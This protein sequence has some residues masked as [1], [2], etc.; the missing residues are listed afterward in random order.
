[1]NQAEDQNPQHQSA[2]PGFK[3]PSAIGELKWSSDSNDMNSNISSSFDEILATLSLRAALQEDNLSA[4]NLQLDVVPKTKWWIPLF[5]VPMGL[6]IAVVL[7]VVIGHV[8][9]GKPFSE[10]LD[11]NLWL[12][13]CNL[14]VG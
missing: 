13:L 4:K 6:I 9:S 1:M 5:F 2:K 8:G 3:T 14:F 12:R 11:L 10:L 7:G